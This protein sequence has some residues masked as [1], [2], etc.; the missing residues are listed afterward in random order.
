MGLLAVP[1]VGAEQSQATG[2]GGAD[3]IEN[4]I[5]DD[6]KPISALIKERVPDP[7]FTFSRG[8]AQT[9]KLALRGQTVTPSHWPYAA[10]LLTALWASHRMAGSAVRFTAVG[11]SARGRPADQ[12]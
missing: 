2:F 6:A 5:A 12:M 7:T 1:N 8:W 11:T 10:I 3:A 4:Q 9:A